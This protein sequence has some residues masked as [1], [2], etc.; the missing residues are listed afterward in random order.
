[1]VLED[2]DHSLEGWEFGGI[3]RSGLLKEGKKEKKKR[4]KTE[5]KRRKKKKTKGM[6]VG[7]FFSF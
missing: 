7:I 1:M 2:L 5:G 4:V 3:K 6:F